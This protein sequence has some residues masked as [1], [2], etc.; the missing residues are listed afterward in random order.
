MKVF[1][2]VF[3]GKWFSEILIVLGAEIGDDSLPA[4]KVHDVV[5]KVE[6]KV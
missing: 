3:T 2:D 4:T 1:K 6:D 5:Y